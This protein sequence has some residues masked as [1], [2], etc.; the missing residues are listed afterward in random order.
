MFFVDEKIVQ[1]TTGT[2]DFYFKLRNV[3]DHETLRTFGVSSPNSIEASLFYLDEGNLAPTSASFGS[4]GGGYTFGGVNDIVGPLVGSGGN[5]HAPSSDPTR[6]H[7]YKRKPSKHFLQQLRRLR[8]PTPAAP[9][10]V[11]D[12]PEPGRAFAGAHSPPSVGRP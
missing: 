1:N 12:V 2:L 10:V 11:P 8:Y 5:R 9:D 6:Q 4:L 7:L 3:S